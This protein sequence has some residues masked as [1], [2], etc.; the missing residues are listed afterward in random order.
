VVGSTDREL[1]LWNS[2]TGRSTHLAPHPADAAFAG[3][4][5]ILFVLAAGTL[6]AHDRDGKP[7]ATVA[8]KVDFFKRSSRGAAVL[9]LMGADGAGLWNQQGS[10]MLPK[11]GPLTT[12]ALSPDG[13]AALLLTQNQGLQLW[14]RAGSVRKLLAKAEDASFSFDGANV[15]AIADDDVIIFD[16]SS[17]R[18]PV[19]L[20]LSDASF[21]EADFSP[22]DKVLM[23]VS[24]DTAVRLWRTDGT[25]IEVLARGVDSASFSAD[26]RRI[27]TE[28]T[29]EE[30]GSVRVW[31]ADLSDVMEH[32]SDTV[33]RTGRC[34]TVEQRES[35][36][37]ET[38]DAA[39]RA[40]RACTER[41]R[42][43]SRAPEPRAPTP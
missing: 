34:L 9:F 16:T 2:K 35:F 4:G 21:T 14:S 32:I 24:D 40:S 22:R 7:I 6:R 19:R 28:G 37:G 39:D 31:S 13:S 25:L 5:S 15:A 29:D 12:S 30:G 20:T 1:L 27:I 18:E 42:P 38:R 17:A 43:Q 11:S 23:T 41:M 8:E 26:G 3:D 33:R 36:L 10:V